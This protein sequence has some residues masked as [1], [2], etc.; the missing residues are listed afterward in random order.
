MF[1]RG[2]SD[3]CRQDLQFGVREGKIQFP[4]FIQMIQTESKSRNFR[5]RLVCDRD[6]VIGKFIEIARNFF[7]AD[8]DHNLLLLSDIGDNVLKPQTVHGQVD[9]FAAALFEQVDA[10][11]P[12]D[13]V[14]AKKGPA[15]SCCNIRDT[16]SNL[17]II[18]CKI[19]AA[20]PQSAGA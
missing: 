4:A 11:L 7:G 1:D 6:I 17:G 10:G 18:G 12:L 13:I 20:C 9:D 2:F 5:M 16:V 19:H 8:H 3:L 14:F 15:K